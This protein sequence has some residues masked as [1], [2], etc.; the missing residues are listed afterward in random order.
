MTVPIYI[1]TG[2]GGLVVILLGAYIGY[3]MMAVA[4]SIVVQTLLLP[5]KIY[6]FVRGH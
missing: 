2:I 4:L 5:A 6:R 3:L 1:A